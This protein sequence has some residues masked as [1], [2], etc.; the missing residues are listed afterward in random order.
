MKYKLIGPD[1]TIPGKDIKFKNG[2]VYDESMIPETNKAWF[3]KVE[4]GY[5]FPYMS[6]EED[7]E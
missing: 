4:D 2:R 7:D 6:D 5:V 3:E 1:F